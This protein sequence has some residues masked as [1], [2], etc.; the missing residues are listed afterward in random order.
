MTIK[1][2]DYVRL[3]EDASADEKKLITDKVVKGELTFSH[4]AFDT[5]KGFFYYEKKSVK[6]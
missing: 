1:P 6:K 3:A 5:N 4:Y 2:T